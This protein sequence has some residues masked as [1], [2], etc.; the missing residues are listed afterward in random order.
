MGTIDLREFDALRDA[1]GELRSIDVKSDTSD[2]FDNR[3][4]RLGF[5]TPCGMVI[6]NLGFLRTTDHD[7]HI[8]FVEIVYARRPDFVDKK[9]VVAIGPRGCTE[10]LEVFESVDFD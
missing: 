10:I 8:H 5:T 3:D 9:A 6:W 4:S 2:L 7:A 1:L